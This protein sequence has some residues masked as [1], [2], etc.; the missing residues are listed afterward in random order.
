VDRV[1]NA[2]LTF[3]AL[4]LCA[5]RSG[6]QPIVVGSKNFTEQIVLGE[7]IAQQIERRLHAPVERKLNLGGTLL[8]HEALV[9]GGID[10]YPEYTGTALTAVL[11]QQP[12]SNAS[13]VFDR[14]RASYERQW[15]LRWL[16]PLGFD[17]TFAMVVRGET[18]RRQK[19]ETLSDAAARGPWKLGAGYEFLQRPDG[20]T[21]LV[22]TYQLKLDGTPVT[23]DLGLL[24]RA[25]ESRQVDM[26]AANATDGQLS[27]LDVKA[28]RDDRSYFPPYQCAVVVRSE[29]LRA[30]PGL[31]QALSQLS[32][33]L[34][35]EVMRKLNHDAQSKRAS[36]EEIAR[37][38]LK[39]ID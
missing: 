19:L 16:P 18:A 39:S 7:I 6:P 1:Q 21:G 13:D 4:A 38:F 3:A 10:L 9:S 24:Y 12:S 14:V 36:V 30:H 5:C 28:L 25:L 27:T 23:M 31:E 26:V 22:R 2:V 11:K 8:A 35:D 32:G 17:D 20:L 37:Q 29:A 34:S 33:K 15:H